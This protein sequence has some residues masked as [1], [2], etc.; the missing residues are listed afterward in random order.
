[1]VGVLGWLW[2]RGFLNFRPPVII[3]VLCS[4]Q[5]QTLNG[6]IRQATTGLISGW[7][8]SLTRGSAGAVHC[9]SLR[10]AELLELLAKFGNAGVQRTDAGVIVGIDL[11]QSFQLRLNPYHF[12]CDCSRGIQHGFA[13]LLNV[14]RVVLAGN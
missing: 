8:V 10:A 3:G 14:E 5:R 13:F 2:E 6:G 11:A 4:Q 12:A 1:M 9:I 7:I